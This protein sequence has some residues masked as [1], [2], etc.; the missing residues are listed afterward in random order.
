MITTNRLSTTKVNS[1][2]ICKSN[3]NFFCYSAYD[4]R[5][6]KTFLSF[7]VAKCKKCN[8]KFILNCPKKEYM[9]TFYPDKLYHSFTN[10][11][12][13]ARKKKSFRENIKR[14]AKQRLIK[15]RN[16]I[17]DL[18]LL[19]LV[20]VSWKA[21][22][23]LRSTNDKRNTIFDIGCG[24]GW[25]L[26]VYKEFGWSTYGIDIGS[27]AIKHAKSKGHIAIEGDAETH[28]YPKNDFDLIQ[29]RHVLEHVYNPDRIIENCYACLKTT[30]TIY[31]ETP[32]PNSLLCMIFGK[33][34]WQIDAPRHI[35]IISK[36]SLIKLLENK[37]FRIKKTYTKNTRQ[38]IL[39]SI[40]NKNL[41]IHKRD[42][43]KRKRI[44]FTLVDL[45]FFLPLKSVNLFGLGEDIVVFAEKNNF[46]TN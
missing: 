14:L 29:V 21:A 11:F 5:F 38:G 24:E 12:A 9:P 31:L 45:F 42:L 18:F 23:T 28:D 26:D 22:A 1:C 39:N 37:G 2:P 35:Q 4:V 30:G 33:D 6:S 3:E 43:T 40:L 16:T 7:S 34:Y 27:E 15:N 17:I 44:L 8:T 41:R 36:T 19:N 10:Q 25:Q 46:L 20:P 32:N 13:D